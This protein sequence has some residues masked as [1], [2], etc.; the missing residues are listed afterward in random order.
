[1][2]ALQTTSRQCSFAEGK[3]MQTWLWHTH[4][5]PA[6]MRHALMNSVVRKSRS[7]IA[8]PEPDWYNTKRK[9]ANP[10]LDC[11]NERVLIQSLT[12]KRQNE[13][14]LTQSLVVKVK[15]QRLPT[16]CLTFNRQGKTVLT[17]SLVVK[18]EVQEVLVINLSNLDDGFI[19]QVLL[20]ALDLAA[21][22]LVGLVRI[23]AAVLQQVVCVL[24]LPARLLCSESADSMCIIFY[25]PA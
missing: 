18:V 10:E 9:N 22:Q 15:V 16:Q 23:L 24:H 4:Q 13:R 20:Q 5:L 6:Q 11:Q 19:V 25:V 3:V 17:Q 2:L 1:M 21:H 8:G 14:V 12:V 7:K